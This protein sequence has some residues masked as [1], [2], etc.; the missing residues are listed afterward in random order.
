MNI[1]SLALFTV[2][3]VL[4]YYALNILIHAFLGTAGA[5]LNPPPL[6]VLFGIPGAPTSSGSSGSGGSGNGTTPQPASNPGI[7]DNLNIPNPLTG[8]TGQ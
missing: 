8:S 4:F 5:N 2:G 7:S 6:T 3:Y 1:R